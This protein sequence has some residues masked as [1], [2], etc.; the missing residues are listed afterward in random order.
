MLQVADIIA[1]QRRIERQDKGTVEGVSFDRS[2]ANV[3]QQYCQAA[4]AFSIK[5]GG[6]CYGTSKYGFGQYSLLQVVKHLGNRMQQSNVGL[7]GVCQQQE[8]SNNVWQL[9]QPA[10]ESSNHCSWRNWLQ[11][12]AILGA[13]Y[14]VGS[15]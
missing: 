4:L 10:P 5:R 3:F 14:V 6:I 11:L 8:T 7:L 12:L 1:K 2:A 13:C 9:S 15:C